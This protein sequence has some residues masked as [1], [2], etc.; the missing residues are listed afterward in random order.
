MYSGSSAPHTGQAGPGGCR[1]A[2]HT[3][4]RWIRSSPAAVPAQKNAVSW[5]TTGRSTPVGAGG[6]GRNFRI[7]NII[8]ATGSSPTYQVDS[9]V[10]NHPSP[11]AVRFGPDTSA[12][13]ELTE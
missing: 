6:D 9:V 7:R 13:R 11:R 8:S 12:S 4:Q 1:N 5:L 3:P 10:T 2:L